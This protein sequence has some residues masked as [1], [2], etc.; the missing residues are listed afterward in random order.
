L[1]CGRLGFEI[2]ILGKAVLE[3][4]IFG[5]SGILELNNFGNFSGNSILGKTGIGALKNLGKLME[6]MA[7]PAEHF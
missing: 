6:R 5:I 4:L 3:I 1:I 2:E 7:K